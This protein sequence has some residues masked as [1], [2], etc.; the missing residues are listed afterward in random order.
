ML[1]R[2]SREQ[3]GKKRKLWGRGRVAESSAPE[4]TKA[5]DASRDRSAQGGAV[6][7]ALGTELLRKHTVLQHTPAGSL[8]ST[9]KSVSLSHTN[10]H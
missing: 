2:E 8:P 5:L 10:H 4:S 6:G 7:P 3:G 9:L 1:V